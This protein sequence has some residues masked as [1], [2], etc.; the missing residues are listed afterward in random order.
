M[1]ELG[2][3]GGTPETRR[4]AERFALTGVDI[5]PRQV[6]RA[7][8]A[9]PEAEFLCA[10]F[11]E[12]E[13]PPALVRRGLLVLCLQPRPAR[14]LGAAAREHPRLAGARRLA[15]RRVRRLGPA[16]AG[17]A[18]G[19]ERR[20]SSRASRQR[21]TR[22]SS[23]RRGSRSSGTRSSPSRS[24]RVPRGSSGCSR[25][26]DDDPRHRVRRARSGPAAAGAARQR[27]AGGAPRRRGHV[28]A[29]DRPTPVRHVPSRAAGRGPDLSRRAAQAGRAGRRRRR[30]AGVVSRPAAPRTAARRVPG[31]GHDL[32]PRR[33]AALERQG[34]DV[35]G[36]APDRRRR[37]RLP[38]RDRRGR[39]RG[40]G[41]R[42]RLPGQPGLLQARLLLRLA[43]LPRARPERRPHAPAPERAARRARRCGSRRR[44]SCCRTT[45][46]T[47][48]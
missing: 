45:V 34:R 22:A 25:R 5:S 12:L 7:R 14:A 26:R 15:P 16:G 35:R 36:A 27:R 38:P 10:D 43:G 18:S 41:A 40:G 29:G 2:C 46:S 9:I 48:S 24:P 3:G 19:S 47:C 8:A 20:P 32:R 42:A 39:R 1:L 31:A 44:S 4:L 6:E 13:L 28:R 17:R 11:T 33:G 21:S 23:A 30:P 37:P